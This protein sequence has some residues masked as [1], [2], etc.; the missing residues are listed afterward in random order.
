M[1]TYYA[2]SEMSISSLQYG[3]RSILIVSLFFIYLTVA[4]WGKSVLALI[5]M[6]D[7]LC[8][9][10]DKNH[11]FFWGPFRPSSYFYN[12]LCKSYFLYSHFSK[13]I[14][15]KSIIC[16]SIVRNQP[17]FSSLIPTIF[18]VWLTV[19]CPLSV[20][21]SSVHSSIIFVC[22]FVCLF[23]LSICLFVD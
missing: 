22:F 9:P 13:S 20:C 17:C 12:Q 6:L 11:L 15:R 10:T 21:S 16:K 19:L 3:V 8:F 2:Q 4:A 14:V 1:F 7:F 23:S 18:M 5:N